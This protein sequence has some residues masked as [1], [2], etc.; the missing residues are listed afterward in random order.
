M[1]DE[2]S[3]CDKHRKQIRKL[4]DDHRGSSA[5]RG[6][7]FKWQQARR[8]F[9]LEHPLCRACERDGRIEAATVVDH[10]VPHR[11][12]LSLFWDRKNWQPLCKRHHDEK[13][14]REDGGFGRPREGGSKVHDPHA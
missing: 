2:T 6:Y 4:H 13:T 3:R 1:R 11:M 10:I 9:L 8:V 7:G 5:A 12:D 14:V